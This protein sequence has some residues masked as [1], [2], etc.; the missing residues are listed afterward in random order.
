MKVNPDVIIKRLEYL[1]KLLE[2]LEDIKNKTKD[3]F[4]DDFSTLLEAE[5]ALVLSTNI[6]IDIGAHILSINNISKPETYSE[7]FE[8]LKKNDIINDNV[9]EKLIDFVGLRNIL[10]HL[11]TKIDNEKVFEI[12]QGD[13]NVFYSFKDQIISRFMDNLK[14]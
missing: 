5:R 4:L 7:I 8:G 13:L 14:K 11:Y 3:E 1:N 10:G 2:E 9:S 6:C 12:I